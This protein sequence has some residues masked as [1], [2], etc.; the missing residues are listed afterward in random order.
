MNLKVEMSFLRFGI[1]AASIGE[2]VAIKHL[3]ALVGWTLDCV[4]KRRA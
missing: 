4:I 2:I 3:F 1:L